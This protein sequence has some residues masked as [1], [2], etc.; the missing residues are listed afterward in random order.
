MRYHYG[1]A[2]QQ[3]AGLGSIFSGLMRTLIPAAK[4]GVK[5]LGKIAKNK[6]VR[7]VGNYIKKQATQ[8]AIDTALEAL[9][10]KKVGTAAKERLKSASKSILQSVKNPPMR[11]RMKKSVKR[12][13]IRYPMN[14]KRKYMRPK[15]LFDEDYDD[16][17]Y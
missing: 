1:P 4:Q 17:D 15:P 11:P 16:E 5:T 2:I 7:S 9:E 12:K 13:N 3:G 6:N 14:N 8:A 10:G